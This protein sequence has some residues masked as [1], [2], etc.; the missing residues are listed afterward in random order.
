[1]ERCE[2]DRAREGF[3]EEV[4]LRKNNQGFV[5]GLAGQRVLQED[6]SV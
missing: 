1:M 2:Q 5:V 6:C 4:S 3:P